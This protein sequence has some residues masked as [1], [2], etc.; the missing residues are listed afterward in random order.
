VINPASRR[1]TKEELR[2]PFRADDVV[3]RWTAAAERGDPKL[4]TAITIAT[5]S[6]ARIEAVS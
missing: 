3:R 5:Y 6:G 2:Q 1:T 4:A